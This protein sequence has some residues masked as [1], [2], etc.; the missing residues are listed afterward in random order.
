MNPGR[1]APEET[2]QTI[3]SFMH[4]SDFKTKKKNSRGRGQYYN[5]WI[6]HSRIEFIL[7]QVLICSCFFSVGLWA[8]WTNGERLKLWRSQRTLEKSNLSSFEKNSG[9]SSDCSEVVERSKKWEHAGCDPSA[10]LI[11]KLQQL[12]F[13]ILKCSSVLERQH[14]CY[15][16]DALLCRALYAIR[17]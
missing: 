13:E 17:R 10:N 1:L 7:C 2:T 15:K 16:A 14:R 6:R 8:T 9:H 12:L 4:C 5:L 3:K 11:K